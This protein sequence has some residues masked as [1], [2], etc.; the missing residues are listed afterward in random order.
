M[1]FQGTWAF[2]CCVLSASRVIVHTHRRNFRHKLLW[3][4]ENGGAAQSWRPRRLDHGLRSVQRRTAK[5]TTNASLCESIMVK[6]AS[7]LTMPTSSAHG[8]CR[9]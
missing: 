1:S 8:I 2:A 7:F 9:T 5:D 6:G 3:L 4:S